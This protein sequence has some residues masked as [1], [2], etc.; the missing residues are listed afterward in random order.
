MQDV[1]IHPQPQH[2]TALNHTHLS[3]EPCLGNGLVLNSFF[4]GEERKADGGGYGADGDIAACGTMS[5]A[6][7]PYCL[8]VAEPI[9]GPKWWPGGGFWLC[10]QLCC[11][12]RVDALQ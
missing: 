9:L 11:P 2:Q 12:P 1:S 3:A 8:F 4:L 10:S 6:G 7:A 5:K